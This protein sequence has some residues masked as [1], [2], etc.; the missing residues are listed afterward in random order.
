[1][2]PDEYI[3]SFFNSIKDQLLE[4]SVA[5]DGRSARYRNSVVAATWSN[6]LWDVQL[7]G[8][9]AEPIRRQ[10]DP[11]NARSSE[12]AANYFVDALLR[13]AGQEPVARAVVIRHHGS[14]RARLGS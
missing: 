13:L 4:A 11:S 3:R 14:S 1:M 5:A 2:E 7:Q 9:V 12:A 6:L 8:D 10:Y